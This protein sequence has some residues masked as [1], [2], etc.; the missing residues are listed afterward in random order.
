MPSQSTLTNLRRLPRRSIGFTLPELLVVAG[1]I[2]LLMAVLLVALSGALR[3]AGMAKSQSNMK[4]IATWMTLYSSENRE[5][6]VP[7]QFNYNDPINPGQPANNYPIKVRSDAALGALR[8]KGTWTDILWTYNGL[9][10][11]AEQ[12]I[13]MPATYVYDS[14]DMAVFDAQANYDQDPFRAAASNSRDFP[15]GNG[16]KPFGTG[17]TE[18]T[19]PGFFA[20]NNF[21]NADPSVAVNPGDPPVPVIGRWYVTG[22][23]TAP[24]RSMYLVDSLAGETIEPIAAPYDNNSTLNPPTIEVD[25]R[26]SGVALMGFLDGHSAPEPP[27]TNL[28]DLQLGHHVKVQKLDRK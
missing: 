20:A 28:A 14:P 13:N 2:A 8:Y 21:F 16:P 9:G 11:V 23:I 27:W 26:Y 25:F 7:S 6:I 22:Q 19:F 3:T 15:G 4:Q 1:V 5:F 12:G 18:S 10:K 24:E 17:A